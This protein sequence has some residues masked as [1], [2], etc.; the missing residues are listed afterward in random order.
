MGRPWSSSIYHE[1]TEGDSRQRDVFP[2]PQLALELP[3]RGKV[4]RAVRQ[5]V[6]S[7]YEK[8]RRVNQAINALNSMYFGGSRKFVQSSISDLR[9][10]PDLQK[11]AI[12]EI[13]CKVGDLGRPPPACR[14]EALKVLR[15]ADASGYDVPDVSSG[16]TVPMDLSSLSLPSGAVAGVE[17]LGALKGPVKG[18]VENFEEYLLRD[19]G[20]W[21]ALADSTASLDPYNDP[22]LLGR[23]GYLAFLKNLFDSGV[24]DFADSCSGRV[25]AFSVAKK[26]KVVDGVSIQRQRLVLDCRQTNLLFKPPPQTRLGSLASLAESELSES[27]DLY[28]S[29][30]DIKDCFY[31]VTMSPGLRRFFALAW[32][33]TS[34]E[35]R[36]VSGGQLSD[37][38]R[39]HVPVIKVLPMGFSW[40]FY[41][42]QHL[43][44]EVSLEALGIDERFLFLE[45]QPAPVLQDGDRAIMPYCDNLHCISTNQQL[46][47]DGKNVLAEKL[48]ALGFQLHEHAE[49]STYFETLGGVVDGKQGLIR[50]SHK[51]M[52][53]LIFAFEAAADSVVSAK[54]IQRLLGHAMCVCVL[55]R[56]GM[57]VFRKLY[58]FVAED[59]PPRK[60]SCSERDECLAFAGIVPL[61][62][63]EHQA[64]VF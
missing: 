32:D 39:V 40:S 63:A 41:L 15:A 30:A 60:L 6:F 58:D 42:V 27:C 24:L 28:I 46:C 3:H 9:L 61:L 10:L 45:G 29:G 57:S 38:G 2:L 49:A 43:H 19:A 11:D 50:A 12:E 53:Q 33:I 64:P 36:H 35:L 25:G 13:I 16:S 5:R 14:S 56:F 48:E 20:D 54:T 17:L 34:D 31:A 59:G 37:D 22:F 23:K 8:M 26:P 52:W 44:T 4:C 1:P 62:V 55:N 51:R 47:Q 18:M 7:H 21:N